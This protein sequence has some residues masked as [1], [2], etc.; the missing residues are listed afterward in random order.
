MVIPEPDWKTFKEVK[1]TAL[2]RFCRRV[3]DECR[4]VCDDDSASASERYRKLYDLIHER[5]EEM[6]DA[7]DDIRRSTAIMRLMTMRK[8]NL[9]TPEELARFSNDTRRLLVSFDE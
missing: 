6:A 7:F 2:D 4:A 3:L 1:A 5:D 8:H 9:V